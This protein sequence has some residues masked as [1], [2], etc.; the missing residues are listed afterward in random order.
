MKQDNFQ[1]LASTANLAVGKTQL[2]ELDGK[3]ILICR[4]E[5]GYYAVDN[6]CSH[7][8]ARLCD[9]KLKGNK[10]LCPLHG[11]AF[12]VRDGSAL[13]RPASVALGSYPLK[14]EGDTI[15]IQLTPV[16]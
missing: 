16:D 12:D 9:G 6:L 7:A 15:L 1:P 5:S 2:A 3:E 4:T 8:N 10:V 11:A 14:V 13:S